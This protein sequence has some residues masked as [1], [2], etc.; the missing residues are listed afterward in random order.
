MRNG[1]HLEGARGLDYNLYISTVQT[2][3]EA[4]GFS[5]RIPSLSSL[6]D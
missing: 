6:K 5:R 3:I 1:V 4:F 2:L